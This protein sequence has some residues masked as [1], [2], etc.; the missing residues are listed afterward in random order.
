MGSKQAMAPAPAA[1]AA[2][3]AAAS[4]AAKT[5]ATSEAAPKR[6]DRLFSFIYI[7]R[8]AVYLACS[9]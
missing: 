3:S 6:T 9:R 2:T 8:A 1:S 4:A 7:S 5:S